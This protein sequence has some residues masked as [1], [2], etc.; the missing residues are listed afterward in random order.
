[1]PVENLNIDS[2]F[3]VQVT[4][5]NGECFLGFFYGLIANI[6]EL[7]FIVFIVDAVMQILM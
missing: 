4:G 2:Q 3:L 1:M 5:Y 6:S 7:I